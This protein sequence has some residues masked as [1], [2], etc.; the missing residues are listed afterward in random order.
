MEVKEYCSVSS[1]SPSHELCWSNQSQMLEGSDE[2]DRILGQ[3]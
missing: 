3:W 2:A 1:C